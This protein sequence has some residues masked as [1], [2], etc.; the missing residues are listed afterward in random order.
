MFETVVLS[1]RR[2]VKSGRGREQRRVG[3]N[4]RLGFD[5]WVPAPI[6]R[7]DLAMLAYDPNGHAQKDPCPVTTC[8]VRGREMLPKL[9]PTA[10]DNEGLRIGIGSKDQFWENDFPSFAPHGISIGLLAVLPESDK[11][12]MDSG[13]DAAHSL[14]RHIA[15]RKATNRLAV[16]FEKPA[17]ILA[18]EFQCVAGLQVRKRLMDRST[19]RQPASEPQVDIPWCQDVVATV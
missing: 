7:V 3:S 6:W 10:E 9:I 5:L 8:V 11:D 13:I 19:R 18:C 17:I 2:F 14:G 15:A 1:V 16:S 4:R 12:G